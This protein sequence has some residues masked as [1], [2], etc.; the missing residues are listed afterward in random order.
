MAIEVSVAQIK[1]AIKAIRSSFAN[2]VSPKLSQNLEE[3]SIAFGYPTWDALSGAA[4][5]P[6]AKTQV[7]PKHASLPA[8][9]AIEIYVQCDT[10]F[11]DEDVLIPD[12]FKLSV[13]PGFLAHLQQMR[14]VLL[15]A[16]LSEV[17]KFFYDFQLQEGSVAFGSE[18][19]VGGG[20]KVNWFSVNAQLSANNVYIASRGVVIDQLGELVRQW[21]E[22]KRSHP[23][24]L[25]G[26]E[27]AREAICEQLRDEGLLPED[28]PCEVFPLI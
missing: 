13:N 2:E 16:E 26:E 22:E 27:M 15:T 8:D 20:A 24:V 17:R 6:V 18:L 7:T 4:S 9:W 3:V 10:R 25:A 12:W 23:M 11:D 5:A 28:V 14:E 1:A 19:V 21:I